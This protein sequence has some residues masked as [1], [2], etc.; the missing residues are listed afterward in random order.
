MTDM[1]SALQ[2]ALKEAHSIA[3]AIHEKPDGD[4]CGGAVACALWLQSMGKKTAILDREHFPASYS[5]LLENKLDTAESF[6]T[7]VVLDSG[8]LER[9]HTATFE[10]IRLLPILN[11]DHHA[12]NT[13]FGSVN[14]VVPDASSVCEVLYDCAYQ[15][16]LQLPVMWFEAIYAGIMT[17]TGNFAFS[18][19]TSKTFAVASDLLTRI[20]NPSVLYRQI[21][22]S[23]S[24]G[25]LAAFGRILGRVKT[26]CD[27][28]LVVSYITLEDCKE[29][30]ITYADIEHAVNFLGNIRGSEIFALIKETSDNVYRVSL[31][32]AGNFSVAEYARSHEGGGHS[33]A[34]GA[35]L[36]GTVNDC[37][38]QLTS[39][40]STQL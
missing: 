23:F 12:D 3:I 33:F 21:W 2:N 18:N 32:S 28:R 26:F 11:I 17:D 40:W 24:P 4:A 14:V 37:I 5:F 8:N 36:Y 22:A 31:R 9:L 1:I 38:A 34:A 25:S 13:S 27:N 30:Q 20:G 29:L 19:T 35:T 7:A 10:K 6:D 15:E 16:R 39:F